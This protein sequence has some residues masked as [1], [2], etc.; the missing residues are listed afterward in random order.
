MSSFQKLAS[1]F[2]FQKA[3]VTFCYVFTTTKFRE[4]VKILTLPDF[5]FDRV[6][7]ISF[8]KIMSCGSPFAKTSF[9]RE[10]ASL[11]ALELFLNTSLKT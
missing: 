11:D 5:C 3:K 9:A 8:F 7:G 2:T 6:H 1:I 10:F 4:V